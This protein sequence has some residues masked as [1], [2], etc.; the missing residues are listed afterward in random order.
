MGIGDWVNQ[1]DEGA[2]H[3]E[4]RARRQGLGREGEF[5]LGHAVIEVLVGYPDGH[6]RDGE[7]GSRG[8]VADG[9]ASRDVG[10]CVHRAGGLQG[11]SDSREE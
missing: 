11:G 9:A 10:S 4:H 5:I 2:T 6:I 1:V 3:W 8:Q 7:L